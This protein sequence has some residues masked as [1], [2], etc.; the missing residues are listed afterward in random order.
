MNRYL[1]KKIKLAHLRLIAA[2][3]THRQISL[4]ANEMAITQPAASR[5]LLEVE[6]L[7]GVALFERQARGMTPTV[8]GAAMAVRARSVILGVSDMSAELVDLQEGK[9]GTLSVGAVTGAALGLVIP[10][11]QRLKEG[12]PNVEVNVEVDTSS[13]LVE[14]LI[15]GGNDFV[16]ARLPLGADTERFEVRSL[17][18]ESVKLLVMEGHPLT[19]KRKV[20]M[21]DLVDFEW[22]AQTNRSP[23]REAVDNAFLSA[24]TQPPHNLI[25]TSSLLVMLAYLSSSSAIAPVASEVSEL[26]TGGAFGKKFK[27][28]PL[29]ESIIVDPYY[30]LQMKGRL[31]SPLASRFRHIIMEQIETMIG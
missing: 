11:I 26:L 15:D 19:S 5:M 6:S 29:A 4:A 21:K 8:Y 25:Q 24:G 10:A 30:L 14:S 27:V 16:L 9:A 28:L 2:I 17:Q 22:I 20:S 12:S 13:V 1:E 18:S 23:I 3:D 7:L 31:L